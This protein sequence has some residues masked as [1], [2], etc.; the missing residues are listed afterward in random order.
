MTCLKFS[1]FNEETT[2]E[3]FSI[4]FVTASPGCY[5]NKTNK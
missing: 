1:N 5:D 4:V 2:K 3:P